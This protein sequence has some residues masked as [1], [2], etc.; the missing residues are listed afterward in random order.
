MR[1]SSLY[2]K[3]IYQ[4]RYLDVARICKKRLCYYQICLAISLMTYL[5]ASTRKILSVVAKLE[6]VQAPN[7]WQ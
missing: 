6:I 2:F 7:Y 3:N 1:K 5:I 4:N